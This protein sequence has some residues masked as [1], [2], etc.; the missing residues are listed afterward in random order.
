M[1][2]I[3][4]NYS[5]E[6]TSSSASYLSTLKVSQYLW[7]VTNVRPCETLCNIPCV[8]RLLNSRASTQ[9][10]ADGTGSLPSLCLIY[11]AVY[12]HLDTNRSL[13]FTNFSSTFKMKSSY[14]CW[15]KWFYSYGGRA[16]WGMNCLRSLE[17]WDCGFE[18]HSRHG[19]LC[20]R[21]FC[22]VLCVGTGL[23]TGSSLV[24][25]VLP[26]V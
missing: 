16:V 26:S 19:C 4:K 10:R 23:A 1:S 15:N 6:A 18:S 9:Q 17:R 8:V 7:S 24:Q 2:S 25:A 13:Y 3:E 21:L 5:W 20:V 11:H 22:V 14:V 12:H